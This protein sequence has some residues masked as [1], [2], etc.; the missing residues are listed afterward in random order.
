MVGEV[1]M[2]KSLIS[3]REISDK[4]VV[5]VAVEANYNKWCGSNSENGSDKKF[6]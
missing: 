4:V 2:M 1:D 5:E 6:N 3:E